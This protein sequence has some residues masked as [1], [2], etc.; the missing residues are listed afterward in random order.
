MVP[1]EPI[2]LSIGIASL[3]STCI[4]C[5]DYFKAAQSLADDL[6]ILLVKLDIEK[7]R[8]LIWGNAVGILKV[9]ENERA[10]ALRDPAK[11]EVITK[12]LERIKALFSNTEE[13]EKEYGLKAVTLDDEGNHD[14]GANP[15]SRNSMNVFK[16]SYKR[17]WVRHAASSGRHSLISRAKWAIHD[18]AK[19]EGLRGH[20]KD[21]V[22]GLYEV[23]PISK[24]S[25]D[26]IIQGDICSI[27]NISKL[28]LVQSACSESNYQSWADMAGEVIEESTTGTADRRRTEDWLRDIADFGDELI[29]P[30]PDMSTGRNLLEFLGQPRSHELSSI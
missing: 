29:A 2:S 11:V 30:A 20:L 13:L 10:P 5:F 26:C 21:F 8:L 24:E 17:F 25:G 12:C 9:D 15:L 3:F 28:R 1:V 4:E 27:V 14:S 23:V 22:D 16:T 19:F 7:T 18:K 6:K